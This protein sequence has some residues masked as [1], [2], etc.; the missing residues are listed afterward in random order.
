MQ[1]AVR[2]LLALGFSS[3][4]VPGIA[5]AQALLDFRNHVDFRAAAV[6]TVAGHAYHQHLLRL[7]AQVR[8][9]EHERLRERLRRIAGYARQE[10]EADY[11]GFVLA[12]CSGFL[13]QAMLGALRKLPMAE[14]V[15]FA[16]HPAR[17][18]RLERAAA[19]L[20]MAERMREIGMPPR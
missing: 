11:T 12:A 4:C 2:V 19:M 9:D 16:P 10:R 15:A 14:P 5:G 13:P 3:I 17:A 7:A 18:Q 20:Q 8:L 6:E 1:R